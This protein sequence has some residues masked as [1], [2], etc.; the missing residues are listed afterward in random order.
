M[1]KIIVAVTGASGSIYFLR[2]MEFLT[3]R[4]LELHVIAS[5]QGRKVMQ[6]ETEIN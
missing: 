5:E 2:L 3:S 1:K 4:E 6:Y